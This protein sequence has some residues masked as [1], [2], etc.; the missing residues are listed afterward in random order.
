MRVRVPLPAPT[1]NPITPDR[2]GFAA[3]V[4]LLLLCVDS[5]SCSRILQGF[6]RIHLPSFLPNKEAALFGGEEL[7]GGLAWLPAYGVIPCEWA[8][9]LLWQRFPALPAPPTALRSL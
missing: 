1:Q 9:H 7:G 8:H 4:S 5:I 6:L 3:N 2:A